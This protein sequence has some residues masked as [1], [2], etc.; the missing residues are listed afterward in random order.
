VDFPYAVTIII[1]RPL[2]LRMIDGCMLRH[3]PGSVPRLP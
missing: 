3:N 2:V 1:T